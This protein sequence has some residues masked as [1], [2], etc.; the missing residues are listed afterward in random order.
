[1]TERRMCP[2]PDRSGNPIY[3][4]D[5]VLHPVTLTPGMVVN[6]PSEHGNEWQQWQVLFLGAHQPLW[7]GLVEQ[8]IGLMW[9]PVHRTP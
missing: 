3:E 1:M 2:W 9:H 7:H 4:G 6:V 8:G 5:T